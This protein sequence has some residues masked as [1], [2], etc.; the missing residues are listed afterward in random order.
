MAIVKLDKNRFLN[1]LSR[2]TIIDKQ[3]E[4]IDEVNDLIDGT[5]SL[6]E[7][8]VGNGTAAAPSMSFT[9]DPDT[10]IY[11][12]AANQ[13]AIS[14]GGVGQVIFTDGTIEPVTD[15]DIDL[16]SASKE[17]KDLFIDGTAN[18]D[19]LV[20]DTADINAGTVDATIG[21]TTPAVGTFTTANATTFDTN[22]AA[23]GVTLAGT[24]LAAD[25][26]D[27]NIDITLTPKGTGDVVTTSVALSDGLVS[28]LAVKIGADKDNGLYGVSD[29]QLGIAVEGALVA[30]ADTS[31]LAAD[32]LRARV[33]PGTVN[34]GVT[35]VTYGDGVNFTT[36]L[37]VSQVDAVDVADAAALSDGYLL[38]TFPA[39]AIIVDSAY[40]SMA[41][42]LAE[43]TTATPEV[44][45]GTTIGSGANATLGAVGAAV[46]NI[47]TAQVAADANG[48]ATVKTIADQK[49]VIESAGDHTVYFNIADTWADTA[50]ADLTG[51]I[52][53]TVTLKWTKMS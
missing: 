36:V 52:T 16:G 21:G 22:V 46:E 1:W 50:G 4:I 30:L 34:T 45:L 48:T 32:S 8:E 43:D 25:G 42:T 23:A 53:G 18:I 44:G 12:S 6:T 28:D 15:N 31:G 13:T 40:M 35:A 19:S 14:A 51:D 9:S 11:R 7:V 10:G 2:W 37:T 38:Y 5:T 39:G 47:I 27:A 26:T 29:T 33:E 41:L 24:T 3:N 17:F 49:L 20:A